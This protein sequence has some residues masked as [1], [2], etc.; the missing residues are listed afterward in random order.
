M[1]DDPQTDTTSPSPSPSEDRSFR[2]TIERRTGSLVML[3][4]EVDAARLEAATDRVFARRVAQ[5]KIPGFRPGKAPRPIYERHYGS[6]HLWHE[7]AEDVIDETYREIVQAE[8]LLP[9]DRPSVE[10]T[11]V[12]PGQPLTYTATVTVRPEVKLGEYAAHGVTVEPTATTEED[13]ERTI[14]GMREHHAEL[15]PVEREA[16]SGDVLT[17]DVDVDLEGRQLPP[18][19]RNAHIELGRD[20]VIPGLAEGLVGATAGGERTLELAFADD[21]PDE[22]LRGKTGTFRVRV[23]QVAEKVLPSVDDEFAK[24]VG[25]ADIPTLH[26]AVRDEL[27]PGACHEARD[28]AAEKALAHAV[29]TAE[30]EVPE[31]LIQDELE[32]MLGDLKERVRERGVTWEQFLLQARK[33]EGEIREEW[34]PVAE[35]RARSILVLDEIARRENV[36]VSSTELAQEVALTPLAQQDPQ[37]LRSPAV[38]AAMARSMRNRKVIDKLIG[39]EGPDAERELIRKA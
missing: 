5:A 21:H 16:R 36:T 29:A 2:Y 34:R 32:H 26:K 11:R 10:I 37:A 19:G 1:T 20:H 9:L 33:V 30:V 39:L 24:T 15:R 38:L 18:M 6:E 4:V 17:V 27:A 8:R 7:A 22:G 23:S 25:V 13:V 31:V 12:D 28:E 35:R 3:G 14:A